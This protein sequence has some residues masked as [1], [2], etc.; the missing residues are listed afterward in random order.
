MKEIWPELVQ[1][2]SV[3]P[4]YIAETVDRLVTVLDVEH[5]LVIAAMTEENLVDLHFSLVSAIRN[6]FSFWEPGNPLL[7]SCK[8]MN[9]D[10]ISEQVILE[11]WK[12]LNQPHGISA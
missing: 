6:A 9:P 8:A 1:R 10:D 2:A 11:L 3:P 5:K 4:K 7:A 12:R